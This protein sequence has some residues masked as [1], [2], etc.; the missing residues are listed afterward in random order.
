MNLGDLV[1]VN[2]PW[3]ERHDGRSGIIVKVD[4]Y[5]GEV[6]SLCD[7]VHTFEFDY[8]VLEVIDESR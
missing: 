7:G 6:A 3:S 5:G 4:L 2:M 8:E 1:R